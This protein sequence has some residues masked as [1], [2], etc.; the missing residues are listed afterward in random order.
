MAKDK[1]RNFLR[2]EET[3]YYL[4]ENFKSQPDLDVLAEKINLSPFH[5]QRIFLDWVGITPKKFLQYLTL[6]YLKDQIRNTANVIQ[7]ANIAGLSSQSRVYDLF[8]NIEGVS[9]QQYKSSGVAL[10]IRYGYHPT[11][12]GMCFIAVTEKG[13]CEF[14]FITDEGVRDEYSRFAQ[15]WTFAIL[16]HRPDIT[17][18]YIEKIFRPKNVNDNKLNLLVQGSEFQIKVWEALVNIPFGSVRSYEQVAR[19]IETPNAMRQIATAAGQNPFTYLIPCHRIIRKSGEVGY[20]DS[21]GRIRK[22]AMLAWEMSSVD[23][24]AG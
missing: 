15:K 4:I 14:R 16:E 1:V 7:A 12:F 24:I 19:L 10:Q 3:I 2:V 21:A 9:P 5:F 17:K 13:V 22:Q 18:S 6:G 11:P 20:F 23:N 8:I